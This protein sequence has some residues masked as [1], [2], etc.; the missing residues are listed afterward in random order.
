MLAE[1][2]LLLLLM[3]CFGGSDPEACLDTWQDTGVQVGVIDATCR[4]EQA[5]LEIGTGEDLFEPL[6]EGADLM[7]VNGPQGGWHLLTAIQPL[8]TRD[9]VSVNAQVFHDATDTP[10]TTELV[11][12][13]QLVKDA[14][15]PCVG[16]FPNM[17]LYLEPS[18]MD[19]GAGGTPPELLSCE[20]LRIEM[21]LT[22][23]G[24]R[25]LQAVKRVRAVPDPRNVESGVAEACD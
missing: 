22:D 18:E 19:G 9:V 25:V 1:M 10:V 4:C 20:T 3:G 21:T 15:E 7:M 11:Y 24:G 13:V 6:A 17:Y 23:T 2:S 16:G 12:R 14:A 5:S 8:N